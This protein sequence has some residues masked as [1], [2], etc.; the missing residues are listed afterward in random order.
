MLRARVLRLLEEFDKA[1]EELKNEGV[2]VVV[3]DHL[4]IPHHGTA[5]S[6]LVDDIEVFK[7]MAKKSGV[8]A[9]MAAYEEHTN[10]LVIYGLTRVGWLYVLYDVHAHVAGSSMRLSG[11]PQLKAEVRKKVKEFY[12]KWTRLM[13]E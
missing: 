11:P 4:D 5:A 6:A 10:M 2:T 1:L 12:E 3:T 9:A 7:R 13:K 8:V